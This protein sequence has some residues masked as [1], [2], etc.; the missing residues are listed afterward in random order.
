MLVL[1]TAGFI[2][3][4][5][6]PVRMWSCRPMPD[7]ELRNRLEG[8]ARRA[9]VSFQG[10][11]QW[12]LGK[13]KLHNAGVMGFVARF[14]YI[15]LSDA[16]VRDM[17]PEEVEAVLAHELGHA[18]LH[19]LLYLP[20]FLAGMPLLVHGSRSL[21]MRMGLDPNGV[22]LI[23]MQV[24]CIAVYLRCFL[25]FVSRRF[26]READL[27]AVEL[28]GDPKRM[29]A[30]LERLSQVGGIPRTAPNWRH[31]SIAERVNFLR[32]I[33]SFP[34]DLIAFRRESAYTKTA[35]IA[36]ACISALYFS[37]LQGLDEPPP[38]PVAHAA[39]A[40]RAVLETH[41]ALAAEA[42]AENRLSA[43]ARE[44]RRV[45]QAARALDMPVLSEDW[46]GR[47]RLL[48]I[49]HGGGSGRPLDH[50]ARAALLRTLEEQDPASRR[51]A[52]AAVAFY[53]GRAP[54]RIEGIAESPPDL[55]EALRA[56]RSYLDLCRDS[57]YEAN[58]RTL[59]AEVRLARSEPEEARAAVK[60]AR[61]L[62]P[63]P[64]LETRLDAVE[65]RLEAPTE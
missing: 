59:M 11:L 30:A 12:N 10:L 27:Y 48:G 39:E 20:L 51:V 16:L 49:L 19:H 33:Q 21:G 40:D 47:E 25:G 22:G 37:N 18:A 41:L 17:P 50:Q 1:F 36:L 54:G 57:G 63:S 43:G 5:V 62:H 4:P 31:F 35:V 46:W 15:L 2:L 52:A 58:A 24:G 28:T 8:L 65:A 45:Y 14:R 38:S 9:K 60:A 13:G 3:F 29:I 23:L 32:K 64:V 26:E 34:D 53:L 61:A 6:F 56:A 55:K 7:G 44:V 42:F